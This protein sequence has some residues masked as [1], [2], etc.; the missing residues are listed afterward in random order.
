MGFFISLL[1][2]DIFSD[3]TEVNGVTVDGF[4]YD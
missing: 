2:N 4:Q 1:V 3:V